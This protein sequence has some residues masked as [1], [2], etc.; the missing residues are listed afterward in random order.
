MIVFLNLLV[1]QKEQLKMIDLL[2]ARF[3]PAISIPQEE[4]MKII[5]YILLLVFVFFFL[6]SSTI[7]FLT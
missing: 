1:E 7:L 4:R 2:L 6:I 5:F 3:E